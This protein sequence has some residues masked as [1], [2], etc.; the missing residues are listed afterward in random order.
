ME[1]STAAYIGLWS[2]LLALNILDVLTSAR[3]LG[4]IT[5]CQGNAACLAPLHGEQNPYIL[6]IA[7]F[8]NMG[9]VNALILT[10]VVEMGALT[11]LFYVLVVWKNVEY[12]IWI[13]TMFTV[14]AILPIAYAVYENWGP[15]W[16]LP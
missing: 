1:R 10:K 9:V 14:I 15:W 6:A 16:L 3:N 2:V 4:Y 7:G 13:V 12:G 11:I 8:G 5:A